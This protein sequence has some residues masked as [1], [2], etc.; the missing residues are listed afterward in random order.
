MTAAA[1]PIAYDPD[2]DSLSDRPTIF[3]RHE[4]D[5]LDLAAIGHLAGDEQPTAMSDA[6]SKLADLHD[7][8]LQ[9]N[10]QTRAALLEHE[11]RFVQGEL[12]Q[13][14]ALLPELQATYERRANLR[15]TQRS[16]NDA[17]VT[18]QVE[19]LSRRQKAEEARLERELERLRSEEASLRSGQDD[20]GASDQQSPRQQRIARLEHRRDEILT[21]E[22]PTFE[23]EERLRGRW[24][25]RTVAGFLLWLGY[26]SVVATGSVLALIMS[27]P[28]AFELRPFVTGARAIVA[29]IFP[30][31]PAWGRLSIT[32]VFFFVLLGAIVGV[33]ILCDMILRR[34]W[35]WHEEKSRPDATAQMTPH[36]LGSTTYSRFI[37][38]LPFAFMAGILLVVLAIAPPYVPPAGAPADEAGVLMSIFPSVG[39]SFIG[40][41]IAFLATGV[42][43]MYFIRLIEPR[44]AQRGVLRHSWEFAIPPLLLI[45]ALAEAP[46]QL[47]N[48][49][50]WLP[51][52]AF[53]LM[54]SLVLA[55][56]LVF[57]GIF[58]DA[59]RARE[60][61]LRIDRRLQRLT[62]VP[63]DDEEDVADQTPLADERRWLQRLLRRVRFG[64]VPRSA[65]DGRSPTQ[66]S[67]D[68]AFTS[69]GPVAI[70]ATILVPEY[71]AI[72][73]I[74]SP[75]LVQAIEQHRGSLRRVES[76]FDEV[77][78]T[79]AQLEPLLSH[80]AMSRLRERHLLL[81]GMQQA[82]ATHQEERRQHVRIDQELLLLKIATTRRAADAIRPLFSAV[83]Q[84]LTGVA[85]TEGAGQ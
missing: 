35:K 63:A 30:G 59:R 4:R 54:S 85:G 31:L 17:I 53:M 24:I 16:L 32:L 58:K 6:I 2:P 65:D 39:Y 34:R 20:V 23:R 43:M 64:R 28:K 71:R 22:A 3:Q 52:A 25:T 66:P 12:D 46:L 5:L 41:A 56:G 81:V 75:E 76:E 51:W 44:S 13:R 57:H 19:L 69:V 83:T 72:D 47:S 15:D 55:C 27:G 29:S 70:P 40:I 84:P 80:D 18:A 8:E 7:A 78:G 42:F 45:A 26:A 21:A 37:A 10:Q 79:I 82:L 36:A 73:M 9:Q 62:G 11:A 60:R 74:V 68:P 50:A 61:I 1:L 49:S 48:A 38:L 33:F 14:S 67:Q 77:R